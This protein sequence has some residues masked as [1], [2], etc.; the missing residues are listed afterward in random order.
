MI[1]IQPEI[2][3]FERVAELDLMIFGELIASTQK[4]DKILSVQHLLL[5][6]REGDQ[7]VGFKLGYAD[8]RPGHFHSWLGG[9]I[10]KYQRQG[11]ATE[12][13]KKQEEWARTKDFRTI[14]F[15]TF[16]EFPAIQAMGDK[17]GYRLVRTT[18]SLMGQKLWFEKL[19]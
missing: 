18:N 12:L 13:L 6:A 8:D 11:I 16:A 7:T 19:L 3:T 2:V 9:V 4:V 10:P 14:G 5:V 1:V 17:N 15:N